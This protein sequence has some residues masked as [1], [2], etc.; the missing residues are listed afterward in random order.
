MATSNNELTHQGP[1]LSVGFLMKFFAFGFPAYAL[2]FVYDGAIQEF[3][4]TREQAVLLASFK[5]YTAAVVALFIGRLLDIFH[6]KYVVAAS[7]ALGALAMAGFLFADTLPVYY[8]LGIALG[9]SAT[10][11]VIAMNVIVCRAFEEST[12]T[13]LGIVLA[14]TS[15]AGMVLPVLMAH[16]MGTY[17][18]RVT[19]ALMSGGVWFIALPTW[20]WL[21][22][23]KALTERLKSTTFSA[24][25]SGM[26]DH[27]KNL[28]TVRDFWFM[29]AAIFL[30]A[31]VD[32]AMIQN[33]VLFLKTEKGLSLE[34]V[35]WGA[36]LL[37]GVGIGAKIFFGG[38]FDR[39]S[40]P[41]VVLCYLVL[42]LSICL[43]FTVVGVATM[44]IF[45]TVRGIAHGGTMVKGPVILKH[46]YGTQNLGLNMGIFTLCGSIGFGFGPP[47][48]ARMADRS[49][50]YAGAFALG[51]VATLIA[52]VLLYQ[53]KPR[54]WQRPVVAGRGIGKVLRQSLGMR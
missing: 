44:L 12:G 24:A 51:T 26:W 6:P 35:A 39:L 46:Y 48:M 11:L 2:P 32:Q 50:S 1:L 34:S 21:F 41:G 15:T 47:L 20:Y 30:I 52:A 33:Q 16:L 17:G 3:G 40:I 22:R 5:F 36:A 37:A 38:V 8:A 4:W 23:D 27:F 9:V 28:A 18:W 49:G 29:V 43:S 54:F 10:G 7:A 13:A 25:R 45:M 53:V 14:G 31:A 42:A 19:M